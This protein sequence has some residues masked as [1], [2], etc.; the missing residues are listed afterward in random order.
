M[1]IITKKKNFLKRF[2]VN[3]IQ[4]KDNLKNYQNYFDYCVESSGS[5]KMIEEGLSLIKNNGIIVFASHPPKR[6]KIKLDPH[7]L[8]KGKRIFGSWGGCCKPDRDINKIFNF[9]NCKNIFTKNSKIKKYKLKNI[10]SAFND[11][12]NGNIHRAIIEF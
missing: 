11:V 2:K 12:S 7:E 3:L 10:S 8:I 4:K 1:K 9:F 6:H 5:V